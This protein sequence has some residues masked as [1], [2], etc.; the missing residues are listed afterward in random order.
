M[1]DQDALLA[2]N[3]A[4]YAAF[5][6]GDAGAMADVWAEDGVSCVH[7]GWPVLVGRPAVIESWRRILGA[8]GGFDIEFRL[9]EVLPGGEDGRVM[10]IEIVGGAALAVTNWFRRIDGA[11]RMIHHQAAPIL[12]PGAGAGEESP[13]TLH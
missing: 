7:P 11:W 4:Y 13:H 3:A 6:A 1:S 8:A 12:S 5:S 2:A 10:G 9:V